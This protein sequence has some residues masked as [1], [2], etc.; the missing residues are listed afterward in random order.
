MTR[1]RI[2]RAYCLSASGI[3]LASFLAIPSMVKAQESASS[4][5]SEII[6]TAQRRA[7][8]LTDVAQAVQSIQGEMLETRGVSNLIQ[9]VQMIPSAS[10]PATVSPG[11]ET[12]QI[13]GVVSGQAIGDST[14]GFYLDQYSFSLPGLPY[15]PSANIY[16]V[17]RIEVVRGPSGT[18][19]GQGSLGGTIKVITK[20]PNTDI[21]EGKVYVSASTTDGGAPNAKANAMLNV[22]LVKGKLALRGVLT[23]NHEGGYV[24]IPALNQTNA[25]D[26]TEITGRLKLLY[27]PSEQLNIKLSYWHDKIRKGYTDRMDSISPPQANDTG[28]GKSPLEYSLYMGEL[29]YDLGFATINSASGYLSQEYS[30]VAVGSQPAFGN[31]DIT[32]LTKVKSF[33]QELILSSN[34]DGPLNWIVGGYYRNAKVR[35]TSSFAVTIPGFV[36]L[37]E[38]TTKSEA[39]AVFG[40]ASFELFDGRIIPTIGGRYFVDDRSLS[41]N[42]RV[43]FTGPPPTTS[44]PF[45]AT[46]LGKDKAF[47]P[48]FNL[49]VHPGDDLM[50]YG[51]VAKGFRAGALQGSAPV[52]TLAALGVDAETALG[53]DTLWNYE[54][55]AKATLFD[56][57]LDVELAAYLYNWDDAQ[58]QYSPAGLAAIIRVGD[59]RGRGLDLSLTYRTPIDG[60]TLHAAGNINKTELRNVPA[61][62]AAPLPWLNNGEQLPGAPR[63]SATVA[64]N[65]QTDIGNGYHLMLNG[66]Y[67]YRDKQR[68]VVTGADSAKLNIVDA[69]VGIGN[70][71]FDVQLFV[72]NLT[73]DIG[74]AAIASDRFQIPYPR[75][76]G[77][78]LQTQF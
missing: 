75:K 25:N 55:G 57:S 37:S 78:S 42:S 23:V 71:R 11:T 27:A 63:S 51:E 60:L 59:V 4:A 22:P 33:S 17:D 5:T 20:D 39:F 61:A 3:A 54:L 69:R 70:D 52:V 2:L 62:V 67:A 12:Y 38:N 53:P 14:V 24:D 21:V 29:S 15:A 8:A 28:P 50:I 47:S 40:E 26:M 77:V 9:T 6:V 65:Y 44:G 41:Q 46:I 74:P 68:D 45:D 76:I 58:I 49:A 18:L 1:M 36:S 31:Y 43:D 35:A 66:N 30:L 72:E 32:S 19:Y 48:R 7:Q 56:Q 34:S 10:V 16:D 73:N 64:A 13:R